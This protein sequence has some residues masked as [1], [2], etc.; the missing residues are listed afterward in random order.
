MLAA[1]NTVHLMVQRVGDDIKSDIIFFSQKNTFKRKKS[2]KSIRGPSIPL[3][4]KDEKLQNPRNIPDYLLNGFNEKD[5]HAELF[6]T[7][8]SGS[9]S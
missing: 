5:A 2:H 3:L 1:K 7:V 6:A 9:P 4:S 8:L